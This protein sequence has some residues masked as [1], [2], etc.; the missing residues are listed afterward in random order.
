MFRA[1]VIDD[2][3]F[4]ADTAYM[5]IPWDELR[6]SQVDKI[7]TSEGLK[8]RIINDKPDIVF[9]DIELD[10][11]TGL[12]VLAKCREENCKSLFIIISG[13]DDFHYAQSAVNLGALYYLLKPIDP[14]DISAV[15]EKIQQAL[16]INKNDEC[17]INEDGTATKDLQKASGNDLWNR[18]LVLLES[19]YANKI[20]L[21]ELA[22]ELFISPNTLYNT[23]RQQTGQTFVE[24]LTQFRIE[25]AQ[26]LLLTTNLSISEIADSVGIKDVFYFS[27][28]FKKKVGLTAVAFRKQHQGVKK[29]DTSEN[30]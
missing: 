29:D 7:Y 11:C 21:S 13:Y 14:S 25:K 26:E 3:P 8:E 16:N 2:D 1:F 6:V 27:K 22:G 10:G 18:I 4:M 9:L 12:D 5:Q 20:S 24:Y 28:L 30:N 17:A 19:S 15:V 23:V